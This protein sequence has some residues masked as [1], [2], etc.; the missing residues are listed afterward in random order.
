MIVWLH[1]F[2]QV[3][4]RSRP[5]WTGIYKVITDST[6][7]QLKVRQSPGKQDFP[8]PLLPWSN[9]QRLV[10]TYSLQT[11]VSRRV[12]TTMFSS[13]SFWFNIYIILTSIHLSCMHSRTRAPAHPPTTRAHILPHSA[14]NSVFVNSLCFYYSDDSK[15]RRMDVRIPKDSSLMVEGH[16]FGPGDER[17]QDDRPTWEQKDLSSPSTI[18]LDS[19][20]SSITSRT[21]GLFSSR[22]SFISSDNQKEKQPFLLHN[23][24]RI[25]GF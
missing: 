7:S 8:H 11:Q 22:C 24:Q 19:V 20:H 1:H 5:Q 14:L 2:A 15:S 18:S 13:T 17:K 12:I 9:Q 4:A 23:L 25:S 6:E 16:H 21:K 3:N 10:L